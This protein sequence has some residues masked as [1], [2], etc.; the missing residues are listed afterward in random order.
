MLGSKAALDRHFARLIL[1]QAVDHA[2][3]YIE[4]GSPRGD[5][6][7]WEKASTLKINASCVHLKYS[8]TVDNV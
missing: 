2:F 4:A 8:F 5:P 3:R 6:F 7:E 1:G